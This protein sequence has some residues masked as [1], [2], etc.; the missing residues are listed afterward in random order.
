MKITPQLQRSHLILRC[1]TVYYI[2]LS[3]NFQRV[4]IARLIYIFQV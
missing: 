2:A 1:Y 4:I 3:Q